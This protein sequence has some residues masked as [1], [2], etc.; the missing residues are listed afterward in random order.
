MAKK[1]DISVENMVDL[2]MRRN[3]TEKIAE[4]LSVSRTTLWRMQK[5]LGFSKSECIK[6]R[7]EMMVEM[8]KAGHSTLEIAKQSG[9]SYSTVRAAVAG[10]R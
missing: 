1:I 6:R 3:T 7:N 2:V 5:K 10:V 8:K 9:Y 4:D